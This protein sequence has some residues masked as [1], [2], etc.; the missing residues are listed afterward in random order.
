MTEMI[1]GQAMRCIGRRTLQ[2]KKGTH[3][4]LNEWTRAATEARNRAAG[5]A[6]EH[7]AIVGL[8]LDYESRARETHF[9]D[10][11]PDS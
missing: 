9:D 5:T 6:Q 2:E 3:P 10:Q 4:W 8:Q 11:R 1:L 7:Q